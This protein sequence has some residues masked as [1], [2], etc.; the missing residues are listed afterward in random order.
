MPNQRVS[1]I[2]KKGCEILGYEENEVIGKNWFD[3]FIPE[4]IREEVKAGFRKLMD[5]EIDPVEYFEDSVLTKTG[6][7]RMIAWHN[8]VLR[9][10][11]GSVVST[12]SSGEDITERIKMEKALVRLASFPELN[13]NPVVE[14][15]LAGEVSYLNPAAK[16]LFPDLQMTGLQH[17]WLVG[18][19]SL[20]ERFEQQNER[21]HIRELRIGDTWYQQTI[22]YVPEGKRLRIYCLDITDRKQAEEAVKA[23]E[24]RAQD[25]AAR[26]KTVLDTAPAIIWIAGD[27]ECREITGNRASYVFLRVPVGTDMSKSGPALE[28]L[29]HYRVFKDGVELTARQMPIQRVAASGQGLSDYAMELVF[30]DGT[31]RSVLGNISPSARLRRTTKRRHR[32][33]H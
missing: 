31:V 15:D 13:P 9:D 14:V 5:G 2:N 11:K 26:L 4:G 19:E 17:P 10:E 8:A 20:A 28:H 18:L 27:R 33:F 22:H 6:V 7:E 3:A 29:A 23:S 30:N 32:C 25:Q 21:F 24:K 12:L 16:R 1:L